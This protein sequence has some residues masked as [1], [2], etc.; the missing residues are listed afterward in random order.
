MTRQSLGNA[1]EWRREGVW[2][3]ERDW[4]KDL[5]KLNLLCQLSC[6]EVSE[7]WISFID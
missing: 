7:G 5:Q 1:R 4:Q 3:A 2:Q 6:H